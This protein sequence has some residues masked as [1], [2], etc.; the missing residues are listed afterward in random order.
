M[1]DILD[2]SIHKLIYKMINIPSNLKILHIPEN[3]DKHKSPYCKE[4]I[5]NFMSTVTDDPQLRLAQYG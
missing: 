2:G 5:K 1:N 4:K 3:S